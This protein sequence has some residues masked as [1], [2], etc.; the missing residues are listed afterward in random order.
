MNSIPTALTKREDE[1]LRRWARDRVV[2][3]VGALLGHSTVEIAQTARRVHSIDRHTGYDG[4]PNNT[5]RQ[6]MRNLEV[7]MLNIAVIAIVGDA[8]TELPKYPAHFCFIDLCGTH[9][10]TLAALQAAKAP[11][12]AVH[13]YQRQNCKGVATAVEASGYPVIERID[14]MVIMRKI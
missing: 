8:I 2:T 3:E 10:V 13:D 11:F 6:Y 9:Q 12:V 5:L 14:S 1:A 7:A 4:K